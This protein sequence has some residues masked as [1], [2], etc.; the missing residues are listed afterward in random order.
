MR[1][2]LI[3]I[4]LAFS[5][6]G[7]RAQEPTDSVPAATSTES[8]QPADS[9]SS[10]QPRPSGRRVVS[11]VESDEQA[12]Q[13]PILHYYGKDGK[14]LDQPVYLLADLDTLK[15][16]KPG[17]KYP[18]YNG[19]SV[20]V[21]FFDG[22]MKL[23]GQDYMSFD[24]AA[25]VSLWNWLFPVVEAGIGFADSTPEGMNFHYKGLPSVYGKIGFNYNFLYKSS[26][27]YQVF[28]GLRAAYSNFRYR[29][30]DIT[31]SSDYWGQ[32]NVF[33]LPTQ[34]AS[35]WFGEALAG[36]KVK[37]YR[38]FFMGWTFRY[39]F[40]F[41]ETNGAQSTPWF[42]PG[43]GASAPFG[44]TFSLIWNIPVKPKPA[45]NPDD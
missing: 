31:I 45:P 26:P 25:D 44:F 7:I 17:P 23:A 28:V 40:K 12:P 41:K 16:A 42:V 3:V 33:N 30:N 10:E 13:K 22:V 21:N 24:L 20:G 5:F 36:L 15:Q 6:A 9:V 4:L 32:T 43:Y 19:A 14:A 18:V 38:N 39:R 2:W 8:S 27:D 11:A 29:V 1:N 34:H 37:I 35:C